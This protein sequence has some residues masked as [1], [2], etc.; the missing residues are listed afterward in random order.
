MTGLRS[1]RVPD[2]AS[3]CPACPGKRGTVIPG[4]LPSRFLSGTAI[5]AAGALRPGRPARTPGLNIG[6]SPPAGPV[7]SDYDTA[8]L[9]ALLRGRGARPAVTAG[10]RFVMP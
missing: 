1:F 7:W 3:R 8:S 5:M 9:N 6:W 10:D 4:C 2:L